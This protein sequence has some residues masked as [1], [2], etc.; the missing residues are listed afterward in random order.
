MSA[1]ILSS[2]INQPMSMDQL[3]HKIYGDEYPDTTSS[4]TGRIYHTIEAMIEMDT[5]QP[6]V[7]KGKLM[8][9]YKKTG[10]E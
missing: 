10:V 1:I 5:L 6:M 7:V 3:L 4:S 2:C 8:F 9:K